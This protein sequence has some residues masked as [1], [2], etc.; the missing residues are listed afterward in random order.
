MERRDVLR[1]L[2]SAA[3]LSLL[4]T[5]K[6]LA[7]WTRAADVARLANGL[8]DAQMALVRAVADTLIP[9]TDLPAI[10]RF[11]SRTPLTS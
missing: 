8:T 6:A 3:A 10:C 11:I 4:P 5:D 9:R 7:A 2:A 1:A